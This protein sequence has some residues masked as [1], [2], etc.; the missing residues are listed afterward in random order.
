MPIK[1]YRAPE[2]HDFEEVAWLSDGIWSLPHQ[3]DELEIWLTDNQDTLKPDRYVADI[4]FSSRN[5]AMGGGGVV[6]PDMMRIMADLGISLHLSEYP[7]Q[8]QS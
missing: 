8:N 2:D 7:A 6:T 5:D 1:I 3:V 4:G